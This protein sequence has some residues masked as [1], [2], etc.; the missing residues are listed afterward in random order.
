MGAGA[1]VVGEAWTRHTIDNTSHGADGARPADVNGD[2][3]P[4]LAVAWEEGG[5]IR[6]Y[7]H[8]GYEAVREPWPTV[9]VGKAPG[10]EDAVFVDI[11]G[12][13]RV[14]VVSATEGDSMTIF[15]HWAPTE[16]NAY[17][18]EAAWITQPIPASVG[19]TRWMYVLPWKDETGQT[20]LVAGSKKPGAVVGEFQ[21]PDDPCDVAAWSFTP[22]AEAS[23]V[24]SL[25]AVD[26]GG[27]ALQLLYSDRKDPATRGVWLG[28]GDA[29]TRLGGQ[30]HE[31]MFLG[32]GPLEQGGPQCIVAATRDNGLLFFT[33]GETGWTETAVPMPENMGTGKG[34]AIGDVDGDSRPDVVFSC[35]SA[36]SRHGLV[37]LTRMDGGPW[38]AHAISGLEGVKF[39]Q[40]E[41]LDIDGDGDLDVVTC[42]ETTGLGVVWYENPGKN[43]T[44]NEHD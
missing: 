28:E 1:E 37:Y 40:V 8:P 4:D 36:G 35:E 32:A 23:W 26:L 2:G 7:L 6:A 29:F 16:P 17:M 33:Q 39:D 18:E 19:L 31:V 30:D 21:L 34:V 25:E 20:R 22:L 38:A 42:E 43:L 3:L 12:D 44:T 14:D 5:M 27:G 9:T 24:M 13:G 15:V 11:D 41:L 10:P